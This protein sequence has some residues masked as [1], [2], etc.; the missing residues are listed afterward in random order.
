MDEFYHDRDTTKGSY[1]LF[2]IVQVIML[3]IVYAFVYTAFV[4]VGLAIAKY[5]I[6]PMAYLPVTVILFGYPII[7]Y[8]TRL[9]FKR[10][11]PLVATGSMV[12]WAG[13]FIVLL[14]LFLAYL[15]HT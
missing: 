6:T 14:Y 4:A 13:I 11:H 2:V 3:L 1:F 9:S 10:G 12:G 7:L 8:K 15:T 5:H